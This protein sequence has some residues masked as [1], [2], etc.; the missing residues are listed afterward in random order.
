MIC[1]NPVVLLYLRKTYMKIGILTVALHNNYGGLLQAYA[2]QL[3]LKRLGH[4][5]IMLRR[6]STNVKLRFLRVLK[7]VVYC[8][9]GKHAVTN[10]DRK[11]IEINTS[12]FIRQYIQPLSPELTSTKA[13]RDYTRKQ[14]LEGLVVGSDQV[15]RPIYSPCISNFF[16]DFAKD[17]PVQKRLS[18]AASFGVNTWDFS[19]SQT[20]QCKSLIGLFDAVSVREQSGVELCKKFLNTDAQFVLD[21]TLLL[22]KEDYETIVKDRGEPTRE[23]QLF[24][25]VLDQTKTKKSLVAQIAGQTGYEVYNCMPQLQDYQELTKKNVSQFVFPRVTTWLRSFMDAKMVVTDSFHGCIFS[26]LFNR[27]FWVI[28]N[29][30]RGTTRFHS[31]L[32]FFHLENRIV[33]PDCGT[34]NW[35]QP[36]DWTQVNAQRQTARHESINYLKQH[37]N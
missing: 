24:I 18:Y 37:L 19:R 28:P 6:E 17:L 1:L 14:S 36:I 12:E 33:T 23:G 25:Y 16:F 21:P 22:D 31:L 27:P 2:L 8:L 26:I 32:K 20:E 7:K 11:Q 10:R 5:P 35:L 29:E 4:T 13:L 30:N 9:C 34:F 3:V 15:W